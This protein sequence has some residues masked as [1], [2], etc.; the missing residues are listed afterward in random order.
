MSNFSEVSSKSDELFAS[1]ASAAKELGLRTVV[2]AAAGLGIEF[3]G[4]VQE[5]L[6]QSGM[7]GADLADYLHQTSQYVSNMEAAIPA[8]GGVLLDWVAQ[9]KYMVTHPSPYTSGVTQTVGMV[10][11]VTS[12]VLAGA[13]LLLNDVCEAIDE[14]RDRVDNKMGRRM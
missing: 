13:S 14:I 5:A 11:Q 7:S 10:A 12:P 9:A 6:T 2:V 3:A 8:H 4:V 1:M